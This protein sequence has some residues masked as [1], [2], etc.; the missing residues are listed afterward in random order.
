MR[1]IRKSKEPRSLLQHRAAQGTYE[2]LD[3]TEVRASLVAEQH[4]LCCYCM[5]R[6]HDGPEKTKIE[7]YTPQ[8]DGSELDYRNLLAACRG[9]EGNPRR[10]QHCDTR[11]GHRRLTIDP[12]H[13]SPHPGQLKYLTDGSIVAPTGE[14]QHDVDEV[15]NLNG[16]VLKTNRRDAVRHYQQLLAAELGDGEWRASDLRKAAEELQRPDPRNELMP[17]AEALRYWVTR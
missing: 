15:L 10:E 9:G 4:G 8:G 14:L 17:F 6:I 13:P 5:A 1:Q 16:M 7:H 3:K 2:N 12:R 11:K